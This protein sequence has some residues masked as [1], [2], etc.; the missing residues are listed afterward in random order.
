MA[1]RRIPRN[2]VAL[3]V[4]LN[5]RR[6]R[7]GS[8]REVL[9][10]GELGVRLRAQLT[11]RGAVL[12]A[13]ETLD[14]AFAQLA[15]RP[16]DVVVV[17]PFTGNCGVDF[18]KA[19]KEGADEHAAR[20]IALRN[21]QQNRV[22]LPA[23]EVL[24]EARARHRTTPFVVLPAS[25]DWHYA[26]IVMPPHASFLEDARELPLVVTI[27]TVDAAQILATAQPMA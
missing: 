6:V 19:M 10:V 17:N 24:E 23:V 25:D 4:A 14:D 18:V 26:V 11:E 1:H 16:F 21:E 12:S 8:K 2:A 9:L 15:A 7:G 22:R 5:N 13:V 20:R 27:L 3:D